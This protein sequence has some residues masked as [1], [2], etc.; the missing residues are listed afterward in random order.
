MPTF[1]EL[2][3]IDRLKEVYRVANQPEGID[4]YVMPKDYAQALLDE[5]PQEMQDI[6][7]SLVE[8]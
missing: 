2:Q 3:Q 8:S 1:K 5:L 7:K 6:L 4:A